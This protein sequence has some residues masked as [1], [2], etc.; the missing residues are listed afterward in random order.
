LPF[1]SRTYETSLSER[2]KWFATGSSTLKLDIKFVEY[3]DPSQNQYVPSISYIQLF[4]MCGTYFVNTFSFDYLHARNNFWDERNYR[5]RGSMTFSKAFEK[6]DVT[7]SV[8]MF[9]KDTMLQQGTRGDELNLAPSIAFNRPLSKK[10]ES[11]LDFTY[12]K[13]FSKSKD[14]YQYTQ[15]LAHFGLGYNF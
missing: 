7:P 4:S 11:T 9:V 1:Y 10:L 12:T 15:V 5:Y 3:Y 8:S 6:V 14:E 13:N 2:V